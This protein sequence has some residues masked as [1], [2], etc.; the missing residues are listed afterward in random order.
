MDEFEKKG[1]DKSIWREKGFLVFIAIFLFV[2]LFCNLIFSGYFGDTVPLIALGVIGILPLFLY[3]SYV[4]KSKRSNRYEP[5]IAEILTPEKEELN[6][7]QIL[8]GA[9]GTIK[10]K[11]SIPMNESEDVEYKSGDYVMSVRGKMA[12]I[13]YRK[14]E[15]CYRVGTEIKYASG[16][17]LR[18]VIDKD[19]IRTQ[20]MLWDKEKGELVGKPNN[21]ILLTFSICW[22]IIIGIFFVLGLVL[23]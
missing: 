11:S 23:R 13:T 7:E 2:P 22:L 17:S 10:V 16:V 8:A 9:E 15:V 6:I 14:A 19:G 21:A 5:V 20:E 18:K 12:T 3:I 1:A 4:I